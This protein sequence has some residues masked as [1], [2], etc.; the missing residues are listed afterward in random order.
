[1]VIQFYY[2]HKASANL[3]AAAGSTFL[4][5]VIRIQLRC[6]IVYADAFNSV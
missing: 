1:M 2:N 4:S 3:A 6:I 5:I